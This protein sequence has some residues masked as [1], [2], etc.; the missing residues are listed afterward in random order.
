MK[1]DFGDWQEHSRVHVEKR[2]LKAVR[3]SWI[4]FYIHALI[5]MLIL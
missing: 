3:F 5:R 2:I 4:W 1:N